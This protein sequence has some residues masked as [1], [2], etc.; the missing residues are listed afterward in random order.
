MDINTNSL[1]MQMLIMVGTIFT[2]IFALWKLSMR[3]L[4]KKN[5]I[6]ERIGKDFS[7]VVLKLSEEIS[8]SR[9][10]HRNM[11]GIL[12]QAAHALDD[13]HKHEKFKR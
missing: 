13:H 2:G 8:A 7:E 1:I 11:A 4:E 9:E 10:H 12:S 6:I 3:Y 5:G